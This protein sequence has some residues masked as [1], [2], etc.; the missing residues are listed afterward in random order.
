MVFKECDWVDS[1]PN[2]CAN[3]FESEHAR[4]TS[5]PARLFPT[6]RWSR[7]E[8]NDWA[9][10]PSAEAGT[11]RWPW[12]HGDAETIASLSRRSGLP[13][14]PLI[15]GDTSFV[16]CQSGSQLATGQKTVTTESRID[17][18]S[19]G[20]IVL[21]VGTVEHSWTLH[22]GLNP[23]VQLLFIDFCHSCS[24]TCCCIYVVGG[25]YTTF[26][27]I[28]LDVDITHITR[29]PFNWS[30]SPNK[31]TIFSGAPIFHRIF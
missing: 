4:R 30:Q 6:A 22:R 10:L 25:V 19:T 5:S 8:L 11:T 9:L 3:G 31:S 26:I 28:N 24:A 20:L 16:R 7:P 18:M 27:H 17:D 15:C 21:C 1:S 29:W 14:L 13:A 2:W 12:S 23:W